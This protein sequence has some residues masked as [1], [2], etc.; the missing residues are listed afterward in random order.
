[1]AA[2]APTK[3]HKRGDEAESLKLVT[4][5]PHDDSG[6]A[7]QALSKWTTAERHRSHASAPKWARLW[8]SPDRHGI[9]GP[10]SDLA[11]GTGSEFAAEASAPATASTVT[12]AALAT[13]RVPRQVLEKASQ[14]PHK[15]RTE[16][17][18]S[19]T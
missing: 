6:G 17:A 15:G 1:M 18:K 19:G 12:S 7:N 9:S 14:E 11:Q 2:M 8:S 4:L 16:T 3:R 10:R 5:S 13:S